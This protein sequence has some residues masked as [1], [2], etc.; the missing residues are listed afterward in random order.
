M[1]PSTPTQR[2]RK[3]PMDFSKRLVLHQYLLSLFGYDTLE[4]LGAPLKDPALER[5]DHDG[6]SRIHKV[7]V[8][9]LPD[10][11]IL[12]HD[13]LLTYDQHI[14]SHTR[15]INRNRTR[16]IRWKYFQYLALLF[17]EVYLDR[18]F[19]NP[20][21]LRAALNAHV[22][23]FNAEK[24]K[25]DRVSHYAPADLRK[26]AFWSATGSGKTLLMHVH[27]LQYRRYLAELGEPQALNRIILLTPNAGL[28]HQ[29][30]KELQDSGI[31]AEQ[32]Q[33]GGRGR[34]AGRAVEIID[35]HKLRDKTGDKTVA[36]DAFEGN[37]LVLV[38][39]GHRG[40][41]GEEWMDRRNRLCE[42]GFSFE[43]SATFGQ[44]MRAAGKKAL[45]E[46]YARCIL[47]DYSYR[48]FYADGYG[49]DYR[50]LNLAD[51]TH[52]P[53]RVLYL[54]AALLTFY[55][56]L[57]LY[58]DRPA[59]RAFLLERP[60]W[61]FVGSSVTKA[62]SKRDI[63]D[64]EDILLFLARFVGNRAASVQRI[65]RIVS[66]RSGLLN[67]AGLELFPVTFFEHLT[68][69]KATADALYSDILQTVFHASGSGRLHVERL[70]RA[71]GEVALRLGD[72][73]PFGV[74]NVSSVKALCDLCEAHPEMVVGEQ[75]FRES[76]FR[77]I[78]R[79]G[80][81][82]TLL[83]GAKKFTEGWSSWRVSSMGLMNIGRKEGAQIIQLFG[84]GV[85]LKGHGFGLKRSTA[86]RGIEVPPG[87][88]TLETLN[89]F[90]VRADYMRQFKDYLEEEGLPTDHNQVEVVVPVT[91]QLEAGTLKTLALPRHLK[92]QYKRK[93]PAP[94]LGAPPE[95]LPLVELDWYPKIQA[96]QSAGVRGASAVTT[97]QTG[98][99]TAQHLAFIDLDAVYFELVKFKN[100][101]AW[102]N[103]NLRREDIR[104]LLEDASWYTLYIP[105]QE[106]E[107]T[108]FAQVRRWQAL[109][110]ALL[111]R[112]C[113]RY[114]TE[115]RNAW[116][117]PHL[118]YAHLSESDGNFAFARE[119]GY[120]FTVDASARALVAK[121]E[122]LR[123][124]ITAGTLR[125]TAFEDCEILHFD[126]HLYQPLVHLG[127]GRIQVSPVALNQGERDFVAH[128]RAFY[129]ARP[130]FFDGRQ[131]YLLRNMSRGRGV[132][133]FEAG[134]FHPDFILWLVVGERQYI[135][136]VDPKGIRNLHGLSDPK[137][138]FHRTI[139]ALEQRL[140]DPQVVL[141]SFIISNTA[142]RDVKWWTPGS[143][144][145]AE[146]EAHNV[147]FQV[148]D[149]AT[150]IETMLK[151]VVASGSP[152]A[153]V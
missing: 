12:G 69:R 67:G 61:V 30:L 71:E 149:E 2:R 59:L 99:L 106:L 9:H 148:E 57:R 108:T 138:A 54:T 133:F 107:A 41:G 98:T 60:L 123:D 146:F 38:D 48:Y 129:Q 68:S 26:V 23:R 73:A 88:S 76:L 78:N 140:G 147:L 142:L 118:E 53:V 27:I 82:I 96:Q 122:Q 17:T 44:A 32:F 131:L 101:Q 114:Y 64:I 104:A 10:R 33:P 13:V 58:S 113:E 19:H 14:V 21:A 109:A 51:D 39:E 74:V 130:D 25:V 20:E 151:R 7:L 84:R 89:I 49:K 4:A 77:G 111:K 103:L 55:Q 94:R 121:L 70:P 56:Q 35:I 8:S 119:G 66:G 87:V 52:D 144:T 62:T 15:H 135:T 102:H 22:D 43:Y 42:D 117:R 16:P 125:D 95:H 86:L 120:R 37:N 93:G 90:G 36:V 5:L 11:S 97:R 92:G 91:L 127:K 72:N 143:A 6:V 18:Y 145:K 152:A 150:Y 45:A 34:L 47:F 85:R 115:R 31:A 132:G 46:E 29:H 24:S 134:N 28:S 110:V 3:K 83:M 124:R 126:R 153:A 137:I 65:E 80:S 79:E 116:E 105:P 139:K 50:I 100:E 40:A 75:A 112:Y 136:F 141:S 81:S 63:T 1:A 128:L